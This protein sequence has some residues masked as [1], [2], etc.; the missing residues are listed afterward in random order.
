MSQS[1]DHLAFYNTEL[2]GKC[3]DSNEA[4]DTSFSLGLTFLFI[5]FWETGL[6]MHQSKSVRENLIVFWVGFYFTKEMSILGY[7]QPSFLLFLRVFLR[8]LNVRVGGGGG[9]GG[10]RA[11]PL[12]TFARFLR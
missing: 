4:S 1:L 2:R 6:L 5:C 7:S 12:P 9:G 10:G 8:S 11:S 3:S